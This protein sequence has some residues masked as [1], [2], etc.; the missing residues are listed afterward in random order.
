MSDLL[1]IVAFA[2]HLL[3]VNVALAGPLWCVWLTWRESRYADVV[4]GQVGRHFA[5]WC[6]TLVSI[7]IALGLAML[8]LLTIASSQR[9]YVDELARV[10]ASRWWG[11]AGELIFYVICLT[12]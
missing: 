2:A 4:A 8:G 9:P 12:I 10:P 5:Q 7:G 6:L 1:L 3:A 11:I